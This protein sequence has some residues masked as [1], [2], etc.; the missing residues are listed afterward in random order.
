[1]SLLIRNAHIIT[2]DNADHVW[3]RGDILIDGYRI[4]AVGAEIDTAAYQVTRTIDANGRIAI[5]GLVNAYMRSNENFLKGRYESLP[6]EVFS[7]Y[8]YLSYQERPMSPELLY[9]QT[10]LGA[11]EMVKTGITTVLDDHVAVR[12]SSLEEIEPVFAAYRDV[13]IRAIVSISPVSVKLHKIISMLKDSL[14]RGLLS[15]LRESVAD[16]SAEELIELHR[17]AFATWH[18]SSEGRL[19]LALCLDP[20]QWQDEA[21]ASWSRL[22]SEKQNVPLVIPFRETKSEVAASQVR[23]ALPDL[24][25][26]LGQLGFSN[27]DVA[28]VHCIQLSDQEIDAISRAGASV[29]QTPISSLNLGSGLAP[30]ERMLASGVNVAL[31]TDGLGRAGSLNMFEV[32]KIAAAAPCI[33]QPDYSKWPSTGQVLRMATRGGAHS[34]LL[35]DQVGQVAEGYRA[36]LVLCDPRATSF[37]PLNDV[38]NQLV[39]SQNGHSV[40]TVIIDGQVVVDEGRAMTVDEEDI[41]RQLKRTSEASS[42]EWDK[43][44]QLADKL[45]PYLEWL[46]NRSVRQVASLMQEK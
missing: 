46:Y 24:L 43:S 22:I 4:A 39:L 11:I 16:T 31:A 2:L 45:A 44:T 28:L 38:K 9:Q 27:E 25:E 21:L 15:S 13:G 40:D 19:R 20:L 8:C 3:E 35:D 34:C 6:A 18:E 7:A 23:N 33:R 5:P 17:A 1:M 12:A 36:D 10:L 41:L 30:M 42:T 29:I 37:T 14:P 32:M 26:R